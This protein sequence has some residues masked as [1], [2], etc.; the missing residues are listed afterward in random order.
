MKQKAKRLVAAGALAATA[1]VLAGCLSACGKK[2]APVAN[3]DY[4]RN[5]EA[6]SFWKNDLSTSL[7]EYQTYHHVHDFLDTCEMI[8]GK[9]V[10]PNGKIRKV[11]FL[12]FD[13]MRAD[14]LPYVLQNEST[15]VVTA[16][17][18]AVGVGGIAEIVKSGGMYLAYCGGETD[19][20]T[21][22]STSTSASWTSHFTG[23]WGLAHGI[24]ENDDEK[25]L[26]HKTFLLEYAEKGLD[27]V[28]AFDWDPFFDVNLKAEVEYV[29]QNPSIPM[30]FCDIDRQRLEKRT[31]DVPG[32]L[33]AY[34]FVAP[35]TPSVSAPYDTGMRD[36][37]LQCMEN[38]A[39]I[40]C[41]I[42]HNIDTAGHGFGFAS[43][44]TNYIGTAINC[45][46]YAYSVVQAI[47]AREAQYNE[48]WLVVFANDHGGLG[49][50][51]GGQ[52]AEERT[53]WIA[54]NRPFDTAYFSVGY[55]GYNVKSE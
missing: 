28:V 32:T 48:E 35:Q 27:T 26:Q 53:T 33:E 15:P 42:F 31:K 30:T 12:G 36:Y 21:Q 1:A 29:L 45:D 51:H 47:H 39:D 13:G 54:T 11:L 44:S 18:A 49:Q 25:N 43:D 16:Y 19:T 24:K 40:I 14:A 23:V 9:A 50:G 8:D 4:L 55:N 5:V 20:E 6:Y 17:N 38:D 52:S 41:G 22:Q 2:D 3:P 10:A 7:P 34:N 46:L 37:V